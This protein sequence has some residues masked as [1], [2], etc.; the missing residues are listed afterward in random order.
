MSGDYTVEITVE[1]EAHNKSVLKYTITV[2]AATPG[3]PTSLT[4]LSTVLIIVGVLLI[5]GVV[6][7]LIR[8]RKRKA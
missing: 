7:Y 5:L 6:V 8:F 3:T 4:M 2:G 1:D